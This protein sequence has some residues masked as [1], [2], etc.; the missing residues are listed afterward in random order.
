MSNDKPRE[1][2]IN[3]DDK[4][5]NYRDAVSAYDGIILDG[6]GAKNLLHVIDYSSYEDLK[7][8]IKKLIE[9]LDDIAWSTSHADSCS[10]RPFENME[11]CDC[12]ISMALEAIATNKDSK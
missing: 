3:I 7:L 2:W 10:R 12:H 8:T 1:F 9:A 4:I 11:H 6:P 5:E